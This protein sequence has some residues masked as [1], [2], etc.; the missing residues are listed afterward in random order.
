MKDDIRLIL[1]QQHGIIRRRDFPGLAQR[2]DRL[3]QQ[4]QLVGLLPGVLVERGTEQLWTVRLLAGLS[5]LGSDSTLTGYGAARLTF[6]KS[7]PCEELSFSTPHSVRRRAGWQV[8]KT[9]LPAELIWHRDNI[10]VSCPAYSAVQLAAGP[11]GGDVLDRALR[12]RQA[13]IS[14]MWDALAA[15]PGYDGNRARRQLLRDSR[16]RPWSELERAGHR[17]LRKHRLTGWETN[18]WVS[19]KQAIDGSMGYFADVLFRRHRLIVEFD[20]YEFHSGREEFRDDRRRR[21]M[22][23]LAGYTVLNFT[24]ADVIENPDWVVDCIRRAIRM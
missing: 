17:L 7:C 15:M 3:R 9:H 5:W 8:T 4:G 16:D 24:W 14:Q 1:D 10:P 19:T 2:L 21:N 18:A 23:V 20:G 13:T 6:W 12:S 22:L 11:S